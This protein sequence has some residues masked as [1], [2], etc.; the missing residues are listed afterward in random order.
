M[1][2]SVAG[3]VDSSLMQTWP[4]TLQRHLLEWRESH[5]GASLLAIAAGQSPWILNVTTLSRAGSLPQFGSG[6]GFEPLPPLVEGVVNQFDDH[7]HLGL[8]R[9]LGIDRHPHLALH[10]LVEQPR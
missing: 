2:E 5:L 8:P 10:R 7:L 6:L 1:T 3:M 4:L 9:R